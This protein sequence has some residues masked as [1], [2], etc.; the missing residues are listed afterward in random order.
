[1][2]VVASGETLRITTIVG[3]AGGNSNTSAGIRLDDS[4]AINNELV[5]RAHRRIRLLP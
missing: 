4:V 3:L 5:P 1:M 2:R